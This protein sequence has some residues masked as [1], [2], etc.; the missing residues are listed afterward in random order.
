[1]FPTWV[2]P[3]FARIVRHYVHCRGKNIRMIAAA[4]TPRV[5]ELFKIAKMHAV[6]PITATLQEADSQ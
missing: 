1:M 5:L 2:Q 6:I 3:A 4:P